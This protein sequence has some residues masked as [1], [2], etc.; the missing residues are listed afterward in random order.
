MVHISLNGK[1]MQIVLMY[2]V[3][4]ALA[5]I[6][7]CGKVTMIFFILLRKPMLCLVTKH[8]YMIMYIQEHFGFLAP[9]WLEESRVIKETFRFLSLEL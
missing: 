8:I 3:L 6:I 7:L 2:Y 9:E 4:Q 1:K 5:N